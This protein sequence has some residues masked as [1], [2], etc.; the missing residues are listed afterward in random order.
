MR[1]HTILLVGLLVFFVGIQFRMVESFTLSDFSSQVVSSQI[2]SDEAATPNVWQKCF[3][4]TRYVV[5][6]YA[7]LLI[8]FL[9][10]ID[11]RFWK[12]LICRTDAGVVFEP[13]KYWLRA[14]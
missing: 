12:G 7:A 8:L 9:I 14:L 2:T 1:R 6:R 11:N 4:A 10:F 3:V 13:V 5:A